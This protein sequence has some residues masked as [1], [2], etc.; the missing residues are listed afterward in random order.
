VFSQEKESEGTVGGGSYMRVT[1]LHQ[2]S[3]PAASMIRHC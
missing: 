2:P 3:M 1:E